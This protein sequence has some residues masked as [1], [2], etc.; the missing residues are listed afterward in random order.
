M[1]ENIENILYTEVA[2]Q[3]IP[4]EIITIKELYTRYK[5]HKIDLF[6]IHRIQFHALIIITEGQSKHSTDF[7]DIILKP[8]TIIPLVKGQVHHFEENRLVDGYIISFNEAFITENISESN[9]FH[10]LQLYHSTDLKIAET[11]IK[12][13]MPFLE[14]LKQ[15]QNNTNTNLKADLVRAIF[16]SLL[17]EIK[18]LTAYQNQTIESKRFKDFIQ[19]KQLVAIHYKV[20]HN[21]KD[22]AKLLSV[23]YKYLNDICKEMSNKTAKAFID[24]WLLLEIK[25]NLSEKQFTIQE[26]AYKTGFTEPSNFIRFFKKHTQTTP[27]SFINQL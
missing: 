26:I 13:L 7:K 4:F 1:S 22:F 27:N 18:R 5:T 16:I 14:L 25:R 24:D 12:T 17:I 21:A 3:P 2:M 20:L 9:L 19:F 10:F 8:G 11:S 15:T 6:S 23:S